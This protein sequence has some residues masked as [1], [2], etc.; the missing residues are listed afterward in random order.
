VA[1]P[2]SLY[3]K[4]QPSGGIEAKAEDVLTAAK[5]TLSAAS[6]NRRSVGGIEAK[7]RSSFVFVLF[8]KVCSY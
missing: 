8:L 1:G 2:A 6:G 4:G 3:A 5:P 7:R